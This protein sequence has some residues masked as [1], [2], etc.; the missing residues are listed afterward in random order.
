MSSS[1][2]IKPFKL[3]NWLIDKVR[4]LIYTYYQHDQCESRPI[5]QG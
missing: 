1:F 2:F 3:I 5:I 4:I